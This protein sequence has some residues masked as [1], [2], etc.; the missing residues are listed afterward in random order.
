MSCVFLYAKLWKNVENKQFPRENTRRWSLFYFWANREKQWFRKQLSSLYYLSAI[1]VSGFI[2]I[3]LWILTIVLH[4]NGCGF[5]LLSLKF[6]AVT[7]ISKQFIGT[8]R[9]LITENNTVSIIVV[10]KLIIWNK[11]DIILPNVMCSAIHTT[12]VQTSINFYT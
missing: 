1:L 3:F 4:L 10:C 6:M 12:R 2:Y 8:K 5:Q 9:L 7:L 11:E